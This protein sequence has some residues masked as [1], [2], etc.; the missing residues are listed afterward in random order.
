M[1][2][3]K[4]EKKYS[5][6]KIKKELQ[7]KEIKA[8]RLIENTQA[9]G[10]VLSKIDKKINKSFKRLNEVI[11]EI[12][13]L[14]NLVKDVIKQKYTNIPLGSVIAV[15]GAL[16]YFLSPIDLAPDFLPFIGF[17]DDI[18]VILLVIKQIS[19]DLDKYKDWLKTQK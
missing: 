4:K 15:I 2:R 10:L 14:F 3:R 7:K 12:K 19:T 8:K 5:E 17:T 18:A 16:L 1:N 13:I 11:D 6:E 9:T